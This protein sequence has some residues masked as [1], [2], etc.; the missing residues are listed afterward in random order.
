MLGNN[1]INNTYY[2]MASAAVALREYNGTDNEDVIHWIRDMK[3]I[4]QTAGLND[5]QIRSLVILKL[6]GQAQSW[7]SAIYEATPD[8]QLDTLLES[9][10]KRFQNKKAINMAVESFLKR[11]TVKS[12]AEFV[13]MLNEITL[14]LTGQQINLESLIRLMI[15]KSP[16]ELRTLLFQISYENPDWQDIMKKA[17]NVIWIPFPENRADE[18]I[19]GNV[20]S[21]KSK[22]QIRKRDNDTNK[23]CIVHNKGNHDT[24]S[25]MIY[26]DLLQRGYKIEKIKKINHLAEDIEDKR[27]D[28]TESENKNFNLYSVFNNNKHNPFQTLAIINGKHTRALID[29]GADTSIIHISSLPKNT[30]LNKNEP[31]VIIKSATS[32]RLKIVGNVRNLR[33]CINNQTFYLDAYV[34]KDKPEYLILGANFIKENPDILFNCLEKLRGHK[35]QIRS[36]PKTT[37]INKIDLEKKIL[38]KYKPLFQDEIN[39][40]NLCHILKHQ[41]DTN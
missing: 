11:N 28:S 16:P 31:T 20:L 3:M 21:L 5:L 9:L 33:I 27:N 22:Y 14:I 4:T 34:T 40:G 41:I 25:C 23:Y 12:K 37:K 18:R 2:D 7:C 38:E 13:E 8:I 19:V 17:E 10:K 29:T 24:N 36:S 26:K 39:T 30:L 32:D 1:T 15:Q 35:V 6:R